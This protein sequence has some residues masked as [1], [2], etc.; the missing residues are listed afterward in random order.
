M[1][2]S[3]K[4]DLPRRGSIKFDHRRPNDLTGRVISLKDLDLGK[5]SNET[6][7]HLI[8]ALNNGAQLDRESLIELMSM[9]RRLSTKTARTL[10]EA[11]DNGASFDKESLIKLVRLQLASGPLSSTTKSS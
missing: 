3:T 4:C 1:K 9:N 11:L 5:L 2:D 6:A 7:E 10:I 8:E